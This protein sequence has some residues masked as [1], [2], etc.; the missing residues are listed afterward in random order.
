MA[1][2]AVEVLRRSIESGRRRIAQ[3]VRPMYHAI[4]RTT[5]DGAVD[6]TIRELPIVHLFAPDDHR[7]QD[8]AR[9]LIARTLG[10]DHD[11]FDVTTE[12]DAST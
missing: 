3:G 2:P 11:V 7:A 4:F 6:V 5:P 8:A 1:A 9:Q 10:V 12:D